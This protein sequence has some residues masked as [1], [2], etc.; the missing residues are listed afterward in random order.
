MPG[1]LGHTRGG[2]QNFAYV[3]TK[4]ADFG[5]HS[6]LKIHRFF[7]FCSTS[8]T[9][10]PFSIFVILGVLKRRSKISSFCKGKILK[11]TL[12]LVAFLRSRGAQKEV[13]KMSFLLKN[14]IV[15][16]KHRF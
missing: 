1:G 16:E 8:L 15:W 6:F 11:K 12:V 3:Y 14:V 13:K 9:G 10:R 2:F 4:E 5:G 7:V